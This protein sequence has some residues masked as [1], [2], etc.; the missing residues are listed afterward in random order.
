MDA[1]RSAARV[2]GINLSA[3]VERPTG[4]PPNATKIQGVAGINLSAF[5]ER[6]PGG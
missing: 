2:A 4:K 3:F 5:V 6:S 1:F